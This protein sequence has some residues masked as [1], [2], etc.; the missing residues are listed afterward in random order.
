MTNK[1]P[2][3]YVRIERNGITKTLNK[4]ALD[5]RPSH[6]QLDTAR[7]EAERLLDGWVN[8]WHGHLGAHIYLEEDLTP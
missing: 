7:A 8:Q 5:P 1:R 4:I 2:A 6:K 3:I